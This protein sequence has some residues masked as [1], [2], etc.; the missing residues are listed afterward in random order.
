MRLQNLHWGPQ[1]SLDMGAS[2]L[3]DTLG[4]AAGAAGMQAGCIAREQAVQFHAEGDP[5]Q[6]VRLLFDGRKASLTGVTF[7]LASQIDNLDAH[8][9]YNPTKGHIGC[10]VVP[11]LC[12]FAE[13]R[14]NLSGQ[15]ALTAL[16]LSYEIAARAG[17]A[18]QHPSV[19]TTHQ[20]H[21]TGLAWWLWRLVCVAWIAKPCGRP[22]ALLNITPRA[23][24]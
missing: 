5:T 3:I 23:V 2:L 11:A 10:V 21:G 14:P 6:A 8:D 19:T 13:Q 20:G 12:A 22:L 15:D 4:V 18:L 17:I 16:V 9:G 7:A 24:K 1:S